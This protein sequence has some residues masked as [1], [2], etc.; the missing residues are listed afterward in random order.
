MSNVSRILKEARNQA[1]LTTLDYAEQIFDDFMELH[2]DRH[3]ADDGAIVGGIGLLDG[4]PVTVIGVQKGKNLQ[5]NLNRNFGQPNP[6]GYRKALR[7]MKQAEKFKRPVVTLI[8]TAGAY[9]GVGAEE[10]GQGEAIARNLLEMSDLKVPIIAIIIG[11]GGSGGALALAV[12]DRVWMLEHTMYAVLSP[13]GFASILWKDGSRSIEAAELMKITAGELLKMG[14]IDKVIPEHGYF[15]SEIV[16]MMKSNL[17]EEL[18]AL[19]QL[20]V[21]DLLEERYQRF[22]KY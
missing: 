1:R 6:E 3:F 5:D 12:A 8:N 13:E 15:S 7:L 20:D 17:I 9:P 21:A 10:R 2:G 22:R 14:V 16:Q 19:E 11:E 4:K 18:T